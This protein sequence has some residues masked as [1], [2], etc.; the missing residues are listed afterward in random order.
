[1]EFCAP[2]IKLVP[3]ESVV[4]GGLRRIADERHQAV[5]IE[6]ADV[7]VDTCVL[8]DRREPVLADRELIADLARRDLPGP[9][10]DPGYT[11]TAFKLREFRAAIDA[12]ASAAIQR[13]LFGGKAWSL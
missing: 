6:R 12:G 7:V 1:M 2:V 5:T 9:A 4:R 3:D 11:Q 8:Q 10:D 13:T